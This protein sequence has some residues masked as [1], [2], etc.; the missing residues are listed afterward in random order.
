MTEGH[1]VIQQQTIK[2][3]ISKVAIKEKRFEELTAAEERL[4]NT[5][6]SHILG[7]HRNIVRLKRS[8]H[9]RAHNG[10]RPFRLAEKDL[11]AGIHDFATDYGLEWALDRELKLMGVAA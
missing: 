10:C 6:L 1:H 7:D 9:H 3:A 8:L 5:P 4:L 2:Q 11:P